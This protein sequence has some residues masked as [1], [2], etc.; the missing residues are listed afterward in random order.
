MHRIGYATFSQ[1]AMDSP[2]LSRIMSRCSPSPKYVGP[3]GRIVVIIVNIV[4][5]SWSS[6]HSLLLHRVRGSFVWPPPFFYSISER[7]GWQNTKNP[8][9]APKS[10]LERNEE[11]G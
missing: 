4:I 1:I 11:Q 10:D 2:N 5:V 8:A 3:G 7:G 6:G 9:D